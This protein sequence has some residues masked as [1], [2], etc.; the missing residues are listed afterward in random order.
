MKYPLHERIDEIR[1]LIEEPRKKHSLNQNSTLVLMLWS[2]IENIKITEKALESYLKRDADSSDIGVEFLNMY[3]ALQALYVQQEAIKNLHKALK[4]PYTEAPLTEMIRHVRN[5][6][7]GHPTNRRNKK[8]FNFFNVS[9]FEGQGLELITGYP[10]TKGIRPPKRS[11]IDLAYLIN[12]QKSIF[13]EVLNN[14][15]ETLGEE[16]VAHRKKF[17][18]ETLTSVFQM[19]DYFFSKISEIV[20]Y[21]DPSHDPLVLGCVDDILKAIDKFKAGLKEREEADDTISYRYENLDYA[22]Q[23]IKGCFGGGK[24]THI[25][26]RDAYIFANFAEQE[27]NALKEIAKEVD[28]RYSQ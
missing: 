22:L 27:V 13:M 19:T 23:H 10:T 12:T 28:E 5:D 3:G 18:G 24:E 6:A 2:C 14:V 1:D 11:R 7:A 26:R 16:Q 9:N 8:A 20:N 21:T 15:I 25:K 17:T 4:I